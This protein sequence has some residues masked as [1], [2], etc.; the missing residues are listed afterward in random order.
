MVVTSSYLNQFQIFLIGKNIIFQWT[1][2]DSWLQCNC[3]CAFP[4]CYL[5]PGAFV[6]EMYCLTNSLG[7]ARYSCTYT[8]DSN[9]SY[10]CCNTDSVSRCTRCHSDLR[11]HCHRRRLLC[12]SWSSSSSTTVGSIIATLTNSSLYFCGTNDIRWMKWIDSLWLLCQLYLS[13]HP[14]MI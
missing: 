1:N 13:N 7:C 2:G 5:L 4:V 14:E 12:D 3:K 10:R 8:T 11:H 6:P 9:W